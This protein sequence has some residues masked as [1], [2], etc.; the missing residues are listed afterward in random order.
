MNKFLIWCD[1]PTGVKTIKIMN[2]ITLVMHSLLA[3]FCAIIFSVPLY[4]SDHNLPL[5]LLV[6][7]STLAFFYMAYV[8]IRPK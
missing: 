3:L 4:F 7:I 6:F 1:T 5:S 2:R 8:I